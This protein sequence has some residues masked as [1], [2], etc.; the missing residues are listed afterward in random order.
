MILPEIFILLGIC[1]LLLMSLAERSQTDPAL[2]P[3]KKTFNSLFS[4]QINAVNIW[5]EYG[6]A[7]KVQ[8]DDSSQDLPD[9]EEHEEDTKSTKKMRLLWT[10]F[11]G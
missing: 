8:N 10:N 5:F 6:A 11:S 7:H 2:N 9:H 1:M 4:E 3:A